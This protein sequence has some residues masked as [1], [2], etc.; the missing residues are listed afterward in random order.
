MT[1]PRKNLAIN[2]KTVTEPSLEQLSVGENIEYDFVAN[3]DKVQ[4]N[5]SVESNWGVSK[6]RNAE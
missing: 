3:K 4:Q 1:T 2:K 6:T 5:C